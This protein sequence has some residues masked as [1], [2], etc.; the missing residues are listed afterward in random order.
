M[1]LAWESVLPITRVSDVLHT[2]L[3]LVL[4]LAFPVYVVRRDLARLGPEQLA[5]SWNEASL[6]CAAATYGSF[7]LIVHFTR[8][9][10][11]IYGFGL[12]LT[13]TSLGTALSILVGSLVHMLPG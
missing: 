10:R 11:S 6:W 5:R 1:S 12:G 8:T 2:S 13:W 3:Q 4:N 9:R 7:C